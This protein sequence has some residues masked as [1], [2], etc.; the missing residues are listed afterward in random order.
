MPPE[1]DPVMVVP[2][3][4]PAPV[5]NWPTA[6]V[7]PEMFDAT[8]VEPVIDAIALTPGTNVNVIPAE[9]DKLLLKVHVIVPLSSGV[10]EIIDVGVVIETC[11]EVTHWPTAG[12][13]L[14]TAVMVMVVLALATVATTTAPAALDASKKDSIGIP[15]RF[16][17]P[18][19]PLATTTPM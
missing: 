1:I 14:S 16:I 7:P 2:G 3:A 6:N 17:V 4:T 15:G 11:D 13:P 12:T 8:S 19:E 18:E 10:V 5:I 9:A